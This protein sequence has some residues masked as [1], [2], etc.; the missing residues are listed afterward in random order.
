MKKM[1][2]IGN[3]LKNRR[4][5]QK[6]KVF[7]AGCL[8]V[9]LFISCNPGD[10]WSSHYSTDPDLGKT[11]MDIL[12]GNPDYSL[13]YEKVVATGF[14]SL[15]VKDQYFT[16]FVP[17][18]GAFEEISEY[19]TE[20]WREIIGFHICYANLFSKDFTDSRLQTFV[21]KFLVIHKSTDDSIF[22][23]NSLVNIEK[24]DQRCRNGVVHEI[25]N[26]LIPKKNIYEYIN[27]LGEEYSLIK[28]YLNSMDEVSIDLERSTRIGVDNEGNTIY[29]TVWARRNV[30]LDNVAKINGE[31]SDYTAYLIKDQIVMA[32]INSASQYFGNI[33]KLDNRTFLQVLSIVYSAAFYDGIYRKSEIPPI[34]VS[35]TGKS[36]ELDKLHFS[37]EVDLE[38]SNGIV[39]VLDSFNIPKEFFLYPIVIEAEN[40]TNRRVSN[41]VYSISIKSDSRATNGTYFQ[42]ASKYI[43]DYVE[44]S[45][46]MILATKY[47]IIW[48]GP[49]LGGSLYQLSVDSTDVGGQVDNYYKGNFK[50]VVSGSVTF[51]KFG[52]KTIRMTVVGESIPGYNSI[53]LDYI[54]LI[55][56]E[57][58]NQ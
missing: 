16:I 33:D 48:T 34:L 10:D 47:W 39:H 30:F 53:Y 51:D 25:S 54:K 43:G 46:D 6:M 37:P 38:M 19:S 41:T 13:F 22:I 52:T 15:L 5:L 21:K 20:E 9:P 35:V 7:L 36:M 4:V 12:K 50:P 27:N 1:Q 32:A 45:M 31:E 29:D 14:D 23:F 55:P 8:V 40:K 17:V 28:K 42:Y 18:N 2:K 49:A 44:Y 57:L 56:D 11:V 26:L 24:A 3:A 58:Y